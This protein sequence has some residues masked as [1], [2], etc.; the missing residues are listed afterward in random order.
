MITATHE[1]AIHPGS[2][3]DFRVPSSANPVPIEGFGWDKKKHQIWIPDGYQ[4]RKPRRPRKAVPDWMN[5]PDFVS[6]VIYSH[7]QAEVFG[8]DWAKILYFHYRLMWTA[9]EIAEEMESTLFCIKDV[10][11][12]LRKRAANFPR[13]A[14]AKA[15]EQSL[16][17][18]L[19]SCGQT[20]RE[21]AKTMGISVGKAS[22]LRSVH[23]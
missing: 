14:E 17:S 22:G 7:P 11:K 8:D 3:D 1:G 12:N 23:L 13:K 5:D 2:P 21:V 4:E 6:E 19:Y 16:A 10:L 15:D 9:S 18:E 20:V